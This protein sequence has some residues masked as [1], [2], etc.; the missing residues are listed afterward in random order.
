MKKLLPLLAL[1]STLTYA[2]DIQPF[3]GMDISTS[4]VGYETKRVGT[5]TMSFG[6]GYYTNDIDDT[7]LTTYNGNP[8]GFKIGAI[9]GRTHRMHINYFNEGVEDSEINIDVET[10]S[11]KYDYLFDIASGF[12]P[13]V[14]AHIGQNKL[15]FN[16]EE[17]TGIMYGVQLGVLYELHKNF[18][19]ELSGNYSF[20][21]AN[22]KINDTVLVTN[23]SVFN[24]DAGFELKS[25]AKISLGF[26]VKF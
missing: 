1:A 23:S 9:I 22:V 7:S 6:G 20:A 8:I 2:I 10:A 15:Q 21:T 11:L 4:K 14:G 16:G 3:V 13:Y 5:E 18:D 25:L 24:G 19:L 12:M 17:N 26:N